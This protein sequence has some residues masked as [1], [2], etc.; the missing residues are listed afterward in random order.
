M[1][2]FKNTIETC[3]GTS[4]YIVNM[5]CLLKLFHNKLLDALSRRSLHMQEINTTCKI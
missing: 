2:F 3:H 1:L 4:L 5:Y